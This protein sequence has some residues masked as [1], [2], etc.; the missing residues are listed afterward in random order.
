MGRSPLE[1][2]L[3]ALWFLYLIW[4]LD[5]L[6]DY[7]GLLGR[8]DEL[9]LL[10]FLVHKSRRWKK[11]SQSQQAGE[12]RSNMERPAPQDPYQIL[13]IARDA[14]AEEIE[15][16]YKKLATQYHPDKVSHLGVELQKVAHEKMIEI[17]RAYAELKN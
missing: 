14:T 11:G 2:L 1:L 10:L 5:L 12:S 6:P 7:L 4:P 8:I 16:A 17:Q 15:R 3:V 13:E 9:A